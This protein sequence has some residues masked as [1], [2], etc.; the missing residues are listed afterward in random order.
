MRICFSVGP[1]S[2]QILKEISKS[3]DNVEFSTYGSVGEMIKESIS[4]HIFYDR[5]VISE[6]I[7]GSKKDL[8]DLNDYIVE[9]S[10]NTS[11]VFICKENGG[12]KERVFNTLFNSPLYTVVLGSPLTMVI[13]LD[14]VKEDITSLKAKYYM[15]DKK[16]TKVITSRYTE[17]NSNVQEVNKTVPEK[18]HKKG[19]LS[20]LFSKKG[21]SAKKQGIK[22]S[23][24]KD[25]IDVGN[26][27]NIVSKNSTEKVL[28][29]ASVVGAIGANSI[30]NI[31]VSENRRDGNFNIYPEV[32]GFNGTDDSSVSNSTGGFETGN[33]GLGFMGEQHVD[34]GFL[35][36]ESENEL[37][38]V[39]KGL[40][41]D[42]TGNLSLKTNKE[43]I[44]SPIE[45]EIVSSE[46]I[47]KGYNKSKILIGG[48]NIGVTSY[49]VNF[50][51]KSVNEGK[52]VLIL[53]LDYKENGILSYIDADMFYEKECS[54][55]IDNIIK[56]TEDGVDIISNGYGLFIKEENL[57][58]L[59]S[60]G[61]FNEY[62]LVLVD[63]P[64]DCIDSLS[65]SLISTSDIA[66][67]IE[68]NRG[69]IM[70]TLKVLTSRN[71]L[72]PSKEDSLF[73]GSIFSIVNK[74][75]TYEEDIAYVEKTCFFGRYDWLSK[76]S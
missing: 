45:K 54:R 14:F 11:I 62:D 51:L 1:K 68:G 47:W 9:Y 61:T 55:G 17:N 33:L 36:E 58:K 52:K 34:T 42:S 23:K 60:L 30:P 46:N 39:L 7:I 10:D 18:T 20:S 40:G 22:N 26:T 6:N 29:T 53:D 12:E 31:P 38:E 69:S 63:C 74:L 8:K 71:T 73:G 48:R 44:Q 50:A 49:I 4:R 41:D 15:L 66:I 35:D 64:L 43:V 57:E 32:S 13:L 37:N 56:Y 21:T 16:E 28:E 2:T 70:A 27:L 72:S 19:F 3:A 59:V 65:E 25:T 5:I 24:L 76:I 75:S 67:K